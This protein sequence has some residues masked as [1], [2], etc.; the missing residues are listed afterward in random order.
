[1]GIPSVYIGSR[2]FAPGAKIGLPLGAHAEG[3]ATLRLPAGPGQGQPHPV[4]RYLHRDSGRRYFL[5]PLTA[6]LG[7]P[8]GGWRLFEYGPG[9]CPCS[10]PGGADVPDNQRRAALVR[11]AQ[12]SPKPGRR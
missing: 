8:A 7:G 5:L 9:D 2:D 10:Y 3:V 12:A 11:A 1:M 4:H 6:A